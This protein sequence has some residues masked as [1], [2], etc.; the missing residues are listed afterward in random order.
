[1]SDNHISPRNASLCLQIERTRLLM[2]SVHTRAA[3]YDA[4]RGASK[5]LQ[6]ISNEPRCWDRGRYN[7]AGELIE[8][9]IVFIEKI[10]GE[11]D[12]I[13]DLD[14]PADPVDF[15]ENAWLRLRMEAFHAED[16]P[17]FA[18]LAAQLASKHRDVE[19]RSRRASA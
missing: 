19:S 1:M 13:V 3:V 5:A 7:A 4:M 8:E 18:A 2:I 15:E 10:V 6:G 16:L 12:R 14:A 11:L 17:A 9:I